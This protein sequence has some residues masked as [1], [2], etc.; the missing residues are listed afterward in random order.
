M[1]SDQSRYQFDYQSYLCRRWNWQKCVK[2][3]CCKSFRLI[4]ST[5]RVAVLALCS[6]YSGRC[7]R[8]FTTMQQWIWLYSVIFCGPKRT[9]HFS[10]C[11]INSLCTWQHCFGFHLNLNFGHQTQKIHFSKFSFT[12]ARLSLT[13]CACIEMPTGWFPYRPSAQFDKINM[14]FGVVNQFYSID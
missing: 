13:V 1:L 9:R 8:S 10:Q 11:F 12:A 7:L 2:G 5:N 6:D 4:R 14:A 3:N